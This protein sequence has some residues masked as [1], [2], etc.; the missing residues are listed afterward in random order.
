VES[1]NTAVRL[2]WRKTSDGSVL[3]GNGKVIFFSTER[4]VK[5]VCL[6]DCCFICGAK[7]NTKPFNDEHIFPEWLLR[8]YDLFQRRITLPNGA[9][10][11]YD[12]YTVPCCAECNSLMG[13]KIE[14]PMSE[15]IQGAVGSINE[16]ITKGNALMLF[17][18]LGLI[19]V[20]VH[21]K[22]KAFRFHLD[23]RI[24]E[25]KI[26]DMYEWRQLHHI[27]SIARCFY[28]GCSV[29][30][31][32]IGSCLVIPVRTEMSPDQFDFGDLYFAQTM[33]L[34][35]GDLAMLAVFNDS[36]GAMG[37]FQQKLAKITGPVSELQLREIMVELAWL[38]L[39]L[40]QR[41]TFYTDIDLLNEKCRV[42]AKRPE[43]GLTGM[44]RLLRGKL[45]QHA[46]R[47]LLPHIKLL[48][49][50]KAEMLEAIEAGN[51]SFL[52]DRNGEFIEDSS[53][54]C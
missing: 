35:V 21:L 44:D 43:L 4:F 11:R 5:D 18:W 23:A 16:R 22:D 52:F 41:P 28:T 10:A 24:G 13:D 54:L 7:P 50:R 47:H 2:M 33:L 53:T 45:L 40:K 26:A 8:R 1:V 31:E 38:N 34:R 39:H 36:G 14:K 9:T 25:E 51:L 17:V 42:V 30:T 12:R 20:K 49:G 37:Y 46:M 27:H 32:A 19:F 15:I 3:D 6:G 48:S 29:E